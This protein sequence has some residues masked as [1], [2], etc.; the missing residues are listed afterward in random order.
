MWLFFLFKADNEDAKECAD[1][2]SVSLEMERWNLLVNQL[3]DL[4]TVVVFCYSLETEA[5]T[6]QKS[7]EPRDRR[8]FPELLP[9]VNVLGK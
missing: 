8:K 3:E 2:V 1:W 6:R 7:E 4:L 9:N 5:N